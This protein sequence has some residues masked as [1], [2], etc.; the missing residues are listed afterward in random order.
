MDRNEQFQIIWKHYQ[1]LLIRLSTRYSLQGEY[2]EAYAVASCALYEAF[3]HFDPSKG[4]FAPYAKRYIQGKLL[5]YLKKELRFRKQH[6]FPSQNE[7]DMDWQDNIVSTSIYHPFALSA[8]IIIALRQLSKR[9]QLAIIHYYVLDR[10]LEELAIMEGVT[11]STVSTWK[12]RGL[13]K[14]QKIL[15]TMQSE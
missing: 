1:P 12:R 3:V 10:S 2:E 13:A 14:L 6:A 4:H 11:H 5:N 9:E 7:E 8:E 15:S